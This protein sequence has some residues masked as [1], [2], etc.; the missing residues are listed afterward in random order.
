[1]KLVALNICK[2]RI[3]SELV[4]TVIYIATSYDETITKAV[5][6][7]KMVSFEVLERFKL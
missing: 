3:V 6:Q 5:V 1:M 7:S 4:S 2:V